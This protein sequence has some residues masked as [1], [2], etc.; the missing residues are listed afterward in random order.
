MYLTKRIGIYAMYDFEEIGGEI[1][2]TKEGEKIPVNL[3]KVQYVAEQV[4]YWRKA[5]AIHRW[6]VEN[7][8]NGEDDCKEYYVS[9]EQ[10]KEL[11][12]TC[13]EVLRNHSKASKLL[14]SQEGFFFG[15]TEYNEGYFQ[16]LKDTVKQIEEGLKQEYPKG[17]YVSFYYD[18]SW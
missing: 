11:V 2:L 10:L 1:A 15:S 9:E 14:P 6:F 4:A 3:N 12:K 7:V 17:V 8:Q 18:S 13:K 16:D 5:N